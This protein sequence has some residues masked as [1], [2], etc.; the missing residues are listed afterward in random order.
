MIS[1]R[2][3]HF[4]TVITLAA[5]ALTGTATSIAAGPAAASEPASSQANEARAFDRGIVGVWRVEVQSFDCSTNSPL[6][7]PFSSVLTFHEGGTMTGSTTNPAFAP[8]QRGIDQGI[9]SREGANT[10]RA[11]DVAQ[12]SF[13]SAPNP[14]S[15][16]GFEAGSQI[17]AQTIT[18]NEGSDRFTSRATT[19]FLDGDGNLYRQG[20]ATAVAVRFP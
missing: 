19:E 8:G 5:L 3:N 11:K 6:G 14:P 18:L 10:Y 7:P 17:L 1:I 16:P 2:R 12:L 20:C 15:S 13:T 9:W 4:T